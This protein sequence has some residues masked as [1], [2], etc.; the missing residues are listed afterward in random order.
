[1]SEKLLVILPLNLGHVFVVCNAKDWQRLFEAYT[2]V[3]EDTCI[4]V[5]DLEGNQVSVNIYVAVKSA[6]FM[7]M[8]EAFE[9]LVDQLSGSGV[10]FFDEICYFLHQD[11]KWNEETNF[12]RNVLEVIKEYSG[13]V[14]DFRAIGLAKTRI[15]FDYKGLKTV[16]VMDAH[17]LPPKYYIGGDEDE[18][19]LC[20]EDYIKTLKRSLDELEDVEVDEDVIQTKT[21]VEKDESNVDFSAF[22]AAMGVCEGDHCEV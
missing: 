5:N 17:E 12:T 8:E 19:D 15:L 18:L 9:E 1:M 7:P 16:V 22:D 10:E 13:H 2:N 4:E 11:T 21:T 20:T 3:D 14:S 6:I